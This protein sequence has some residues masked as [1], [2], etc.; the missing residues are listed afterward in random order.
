MKGVD[1]GFIRF[2]GCK[3]GKFRGRN[4]VE[5]EKDWITHI[6]LFTGS[7]LDKY[8]KLCRQKTTG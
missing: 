1:G 7:F 8:R 6:N 3:I 2:S 5:D 4:F